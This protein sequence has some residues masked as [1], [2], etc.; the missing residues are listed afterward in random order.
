MRDHI[1]SLSDEELADLGYMLGQPLGGIA[2][3][4]HRLVVAELVKRF[5]ESFG[6]E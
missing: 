3:G 5:R 1:D 2:K 4:E 6:E